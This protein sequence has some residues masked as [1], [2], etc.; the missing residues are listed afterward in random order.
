MLKGLGL[1][2]QGLPSAF[3][4]KG[5]QMPF[6]LLIALGDLLVIDLVQLDGLASGK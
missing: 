2:G 4:G 5:L 3:V 6:A 1:G